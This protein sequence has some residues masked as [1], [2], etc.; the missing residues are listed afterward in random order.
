M[1]GIR[2][3]EVI[4]LLGS[5]AAWPR[6][7][8]AQPQGQPVVAFLNSG[9]QL[10]ADRLIAFRKGLSEVDY[11]DGRNV[12]VELHQSDQYD[13]L[14]ALASNLVRRSVAAIFAEALPAALAAKAVTKTIPIVFAVGGDPVELGLV[15]SLNRPGGNLTGMTTFYG[16]LLPKRLELLRELLQSTDIIGVLIN[17][18]NP[19]S[20]ARSRDVREAARTVGQRILIV[21]GGERDIPSTFTTLMQQRVAALIVSDDPFLSGRIEQIIT[22]AALNKLPVIYSF[23]E[24][25]ERGGLMSYG[26]E[27][28]ERQGGIY[29]GRILKGEKPADLPVLQPTKFEFAINLKTAKSLGLTF[30]QSFYLRADEVV[31]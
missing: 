28:S 2:R 3:R 22:L 27:R 24:H 4:S 15:A 17:T 8:L 6:V 29:I 10:S 16:E 7:L 11:I 13:H 30:P 26:T 12:A 9:E 25:T 20:E 19:N 23:R 5:A 1:F 21:D 18:K 14:P 31:E